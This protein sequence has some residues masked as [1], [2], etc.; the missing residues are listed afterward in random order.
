MHFGL[1]VRARLTLPLLVSLPPMISP[2][3]PMILLCL[4]VRLKFAAAVHSSIL[5]DHL[6]MLSKL[7]S[8]G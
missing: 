2:L 7:F 3:F 6:A 1:R 4:L 5:A 8:R